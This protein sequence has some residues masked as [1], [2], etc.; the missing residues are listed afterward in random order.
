MQGGNTFLEDIIDKSILNRSVKNQL[1]SHGFYYLEQLLTENNSKLIPWTNCKLRSLKEKWGPKPKWYKCL[2]EKTLIETINRT[3]KE[4][5]KE[6]SD[7]CYKYT[8]NSHANNKRRNFLFCYQKEGKFEF[9]RKLKIEE[10]KK[11]H[12]II[13]FEEYN[14]S[15]DIF[16]T[17]LI[18]TPST[19][20]ISN[21]DILIL[22]KHTK[23]KY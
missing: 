19:N 10:S 3:I 21:T 11:N 5:Y 22:P 17:K 6:D 15:P 9:G 23:K 13:K 16:T 14:N 20:Y 8:F 1:N 2:E 7:N 18:K 12:I 4:K